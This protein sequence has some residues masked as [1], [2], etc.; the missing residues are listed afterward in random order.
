MDLTTTG[1][2]LESCVGCAGPAVHSDLASTPVRTVMIDVIVVVVVLLVVVIIVVVAV[3][4]VVLV[5]VVVV[6]V[7]IVV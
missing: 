7:V 4:V 2:G 5:V 1:E 6:V 3:V